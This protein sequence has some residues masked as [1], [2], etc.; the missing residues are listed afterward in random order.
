MPGAAP[1]AAP[2]S[3]T[4]AATTPQ[5][6]PKAP[7]KEPTVPEPPEQSAATPPQSEP[8]PSQDQSAS[9]GGA[10]GFAAAPGGYLDNAIPQTMIRLRYDAAW[11]INR[12]DR[13][14]FLFGTWK[15]LG[16]HPH[17]IQGDGAFLDPHARGPLQLS[18]NIDTETASAYVEYAVQDW[19]SVYANVPYEYVNFNRLQEDFPE[20][21]A[22]AAGLLPASI[23]NLTGTARQQAIVAANPNPGLPFFPEPDRGNEGPHTTHTGLADIDFGIKAAII[24]DPDRYL[25]LDLHVFSPTGESEQGIGNGHWTVQ[26]GLLAYQKVDCWEFQAQVQDWIPLTDDPAAGNIVIYGAGVGYEILK[27]GNLRVVPITEWI[28][29]TVLGGFESFFGQVSATP[30]DTLI[31][32]HTHGVM[33]AA[34]DTIVNGKIGVRTYFGCGNDVYIGYGRAVTGDRWYQDILRVEYRRVF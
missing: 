19:F 13:A 3:R 27:R 1:A 29:W 9:I 14:D 5:T 15:E 16:F 25:T 20:A 22:K 11:G 10:E 23:R 33:S 28:G 7:A 12:F 17:G 24:A 34:G 6:P 26:P 21:E 4:P 32:P 30:P 31:L 18:N 2:P 8:E